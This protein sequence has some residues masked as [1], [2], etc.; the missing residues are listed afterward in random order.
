LVG[1]QPTGQRPRIES[2]SNA[3]SRRKT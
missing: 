2:R 3:A 1:G